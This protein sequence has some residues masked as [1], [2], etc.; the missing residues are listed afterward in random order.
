MFFRGYVPAEVLIIGGAPSAGDDMNGLPIIGPAGDILDDIVRSTQMA[1]EDPFPWCVTLSVMCRPPKDG[2]KPGTPKPA[3]LA[4]C[5]SRLTSFIL[6]VQPKV[7]VIAGAMAA[8]AMP[9]IES[10]TSFPPEGDWP[11]WATHH[12]DRVILEQFQQIN[13]KRRG[14]LK[15]PTPARDMWAPQVCSIRDPSWILH[16]DEENQPM[17]IQRA[18]LRVTA[19]VKEARAAF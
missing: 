4:A 3:E 7:I 1:V 13:E 12:V 19:A 8:K 5:K 6:M 9:G 15:K 17:E 10:M 2:D 11:L 14:R 16:Q 18:V